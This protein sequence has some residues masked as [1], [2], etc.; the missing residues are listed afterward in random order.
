MIVVTYV[1]Q[2]FQVK[3]ALGACHM[4]VMISERDADQLAEMGYEGRWVL[5]RGI[6]CKSR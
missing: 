1:G 4:R 6:Q 2:L 5:E 3:S